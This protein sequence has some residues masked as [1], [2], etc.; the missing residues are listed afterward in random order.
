MHSILIYFKP[1]RFDSIEFVRLV[2]TLG[3]FDCDAMTKAC[4]PL[5]PFFWLY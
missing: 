3:F 5:L 4:P 1:S 2:L